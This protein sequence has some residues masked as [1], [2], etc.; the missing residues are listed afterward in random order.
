[1]DIPALDFELPEAAL[2][3]PPLPV[4]SPRL[5]PAIIASTTTT[6]TQSPI[7]NLDRRSLAYLASPRLAP[8]SPRTRFD[9]SPSH[10]SPSGANSGLGIPLRPI[11]LPQSPRPFAP[12]MESDITEGGAEARADQEVE[13]PV[14]SRTDDDEMDLETPYYSPEHRFNGDELL[15][16]Q[17][18]HTARTPHPLYTPII[19]PRIHR[20]RRRRAMSIHSAKTDKVTLKSVARSH[21]KSAW[22]LLRFKRFV[23][24]RK[25]GRSNGTSSMDS[26]SSSSSSTS[27]SGSSSRSSSTWGGWRF[28]KNSDSGSSS[29]GDS[30]DTEDEWTPPTPHF[31]LLTPILSRVGGSPS[32]PA[33]LLP[34]NFKNTSTSSYSAEAPNTPSLNSA[35]QDSKSS[36]QYKHQS[37][38]KGS[39]LEKG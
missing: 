34:S 18:I 36:Q 2:P 29:S 11:L 8:G 22:Y 5:S 20:R 13:A 14:E 21:L 19:N 6:T 33:H 12:K 38:G 25:S 39:S 23:N 26:D 30:E 1:M 9:L 37:T 15:P 28:W 7:T 35:S 17:T 31:T 4:N 10:P 32:Y 27:S 3:V 16:E 24:N